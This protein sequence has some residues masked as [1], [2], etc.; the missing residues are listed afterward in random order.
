[1]GLLGDMNNVAIYV[2]MKSK[3]KN[4]LGEESNPVSR[5]TGGDTHLHTTEDCAFPLLGD[6][7]NPTKYN[8]EK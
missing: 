7:N 4:L 2:T 6:M 3:T 5:V 8:C 1:M